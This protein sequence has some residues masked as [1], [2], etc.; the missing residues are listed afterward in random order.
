MKNPKLAATLAFIALVL[1]GGIAAYFYWPHSE[2]EPV[3]VAALP[4]PAPLPAPEPV[5]Q[6][7]V[8]TPPEAPALPLLAESDRFM[9]DKLAGLFADASLMNLFHSERIIRKI[10]A[11]VD[12]LPRKE[13]SMSVMP[14]KRAKG[15]F[16]VAGTEEDLT[17]S[18]EN[19]A[20]YWPYVKLAE[21][22]DAEQLV[23]MYVR[24]YPL[25]QSAYEELGYPGKYFNDRLIVA[26]DNLLATPD[27]K[28][29][30][31]LAQPNVYYLYA[32]PDLEAR[33]IGQR[34]LMRTGSKSEARL[35]VALGEIRQALLRHMREKK[36]VEG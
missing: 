8:E 13:V 3:Q 16:I 21:A 6:M 12:N 24:L 28:E 17:I 19:A 9:L 34:M 30:V 18:P 25:F 23:A 4:P 35:K 22:I 29:P 27:I 11:T 26:L 14:L 36:V 20:R 32:D 1:C 5:V 31:G 7:V 33:S 10:V 15:E 2:P